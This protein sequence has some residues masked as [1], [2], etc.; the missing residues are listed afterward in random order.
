MNCPICNKDCVKDWVFYPP[1]YR[2]KEYSYTCKI[3][4][5]SISFE[6]DKVIFYEIQIGR[7]TLRAAI[8]TQYKEYLEIIEYN[9]LNPYIPLLLIDKFIPISNPSSLD[10][11]K[12]LINRLLN[13]KAFS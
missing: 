13:M 3:C 6:L 9:G 12:S 10:S 4:G 8:K 5:F 11:Y 2:S 7:K 1:S